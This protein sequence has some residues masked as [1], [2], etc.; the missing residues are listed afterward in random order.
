[1]KKLSSFIKHSKKGKIIAI[2]IVLGLCVL[3]ISLYTFLTITTDTL[4]E[5]KLVQI[6]YELSHQLYA[7]RT[8]QM[9][10]MMLVISFLG[11][12]FTVAATAAI[13]V[14]LYKKK[15]TQESLVFALLMGFGAFANYLLKN[16][17]QRAR[18]TFDPLVHHASYSFP[19]AHAMNSFIFYVTVAYLTYHLTGNKKTTIIV[20]AISISMII[21]TGLSR[22]Y[23]GVHYPSDILAGYYA[24]LVWF[25]G[26]L[27]IERA[28]TFMK[29][30][31]R[32]E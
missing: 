26:V 17:F 32:H 16:I 29:L 13:V 7:V 2:E 3:I 10:N 24:G 25:V 23:L 1:M 6:D 14:V 28:F 9:T 18:P 15:Y 27:L 5:L 11:A 8:P 4:F 31:K 30:Y 21:L 20:T 12:G 19:S 22:I